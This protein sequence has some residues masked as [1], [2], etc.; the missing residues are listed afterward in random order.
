MS[1]K[2]IPKDEITKDI[3]VTYYARFIDFLNRNTKVAIIVGVAIVAVL[4]L[5]IGYY[6]YEQKQDT[7]AEQLMTNAE[8][9]LRESDYEKA[10]NGDPQNFTIGF[11]QIINKY[12]STDA[13]NLSLYYAAVCEFN[14]NHFQ[15]ALDYIQKYEVPKG[16]LGVG[17]ISLH[18]VILSNLKKYKE[19]GDMYM[20]AAHWE[21]NDN[22]TPYNLI[23]AA[24]AYI[25]A[26]DI[27]NAHKAV[28]E[29]LDNYGN[30]PFQTQALKLDG[31]IQG[32]SKS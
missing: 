1:K 6:F 4:G 20:K 5:G 16:I 17:P 22:T 31:Y 28:A 8:K 21:D 11:S 29:V 27:S 3:L 26:K 23:A 7:K 13:G 10:L 9:Y 25:K 2:H 32:Q 12:S 15:K 14:L 30:T 24:N 19:A 18:A